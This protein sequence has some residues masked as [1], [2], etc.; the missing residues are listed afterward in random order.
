MISFLRQRRKME[1][2]FKKTGK[3]CINNMMGV[4]KERVFF[5]T[6]DLLDA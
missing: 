5:F 2:S 3:K 4:R 6:T 1:A